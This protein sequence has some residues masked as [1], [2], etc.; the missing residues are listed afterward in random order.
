MSKEFVNAL[1]SGDNIEAEKAFERIKKV[2]KELN[3][4]QK[5]LV[6]REDY[7]SDEY[8]DIINKCSEY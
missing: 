3:Y 8:L 5:E 1:A 4:I 6:N 7:D 2:Q